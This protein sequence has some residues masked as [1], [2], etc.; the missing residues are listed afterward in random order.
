MVAICIYLPV[1]N[2]WLIDGK[3]IY[4][5]KDV[6]EFEKKIKKIINGKLPDLTKEAYQVAYERRI[7]VVGEQLRKV[8]M[9]IMKS[10][11]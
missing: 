10:K 7:E 11:D 6:N 4:K 5:A 2:D 3:N 1:F 9:D 8:Y